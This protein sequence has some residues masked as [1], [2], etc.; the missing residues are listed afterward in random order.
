MIQTVK[1]YL[2]D[3]LEKAKQY[4]KKRDVQLPKVKTDLKGQ[5]EKKKSEKM[6]FSLYI[7]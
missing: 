4:G 5:N 7:L 1:F 3:V 6:L 2:N